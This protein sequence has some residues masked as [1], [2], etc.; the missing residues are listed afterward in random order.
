MDE[1]GPSRGTQ[2]EEK[3]PWNAERGTGHLS[4]EMLSEHVGLQ[5]GRLRSPGFKSGK[6]C[7]RQQEGLLE[8]VK[9]LGAFFVLVLIAKAGPQESQSV[10]V[11]E[12]ACRKEDLSLVEEGFVRNRLSNLDAH[13][14]MGPDGMHPRVM[15]E[16]ADVVAEA[17]SIVFERFWRTGEVPEDWR[18]A[19]V[20]PIFTK[21]QEEEPRELQAGQPS[22][23][24]SSSKW[25]KRRLS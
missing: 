19:N 22:W 23:R 4:T 16:L 25:R 13:K 21:G 20:T 9:L 1:Q 5:R 15:R 10:E 24:S 17:L 11:R 2:M 14:S 6:G 7:K 12:E 3:G 18:K 8:E